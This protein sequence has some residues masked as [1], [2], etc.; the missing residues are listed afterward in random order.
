MR[1]ITLLLLLSAFTFVGFAQKTALK[2][3]KTFSLEFLNSVKGEGD[4]TD[5]IMPASFL[6]GTPTL[7][8]ATTGF[9][10]GTN[11]YG[12]M[13][14]AQQYNTGDETYFIHG[15]QIWVGANGIDEGDLTFTVRDFDEVPTTVLSS[16][17]V[18]FAQVTTT[19]PFET[20]DFMYSVIFDTPAE[21]S[22]DFVVGVE[23]SS[24]LTAGF[25]LITTTN[26]DTEDLNLWEQ[27]STGDW[28]TVGTAWTDMMIDAGIFPMVSIGI[29]IP[30]KSLQAVSIYP[31]PV[32]GSLYLNNLEG[33]SQITVSNILGQT[34]IS[35]SV[36][37]INMTINTNEL[38]KGV[39]IVT[40]VTENGL[41]RS[42]RIVKE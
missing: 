21:V 3:E 16:Q 24:T 33:V 25:G 14:K 5:T 23:W 28:K 31:N 17:V 18:P 35:E 20:G 30:T 19:T 27:W 12:D 32:N 4:I 22:G 1:K 41:V 2:S 8:T 13:A 9:V 6:T 34:I 39:Y 37:S 29:G 7:Y 40:F 11:D 26:G 15:V 10:V 36:N 38:R 42:D